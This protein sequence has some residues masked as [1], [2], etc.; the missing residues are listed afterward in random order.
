[1]AALLSIAMVAFYA[2]PYDVVTRLWVI[3]SALTGV[4]FPAFAAALLSDRQRALNLFASGVRY[5]FVVLAP[6][7]LV[8]VAFAHEGLLWWLGAEFALESERVVQWLAVGVLI[9]SLARM[10][11]A[12]IQAAGKPDWTAKLHLLELVPYLVSVWWLVEAFGVTGAAMAWTLRAVVDTALLFLVASRLMPG[13]GSRLGA[14]RWV[15]AATFMVLVGVA[16]MTEP[17]MKMGFCA[18]ALML[19]G[20]VVWR[21]LLEPGEIGRFRAYFRMTPCS[22]N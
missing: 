22:A 7:V 21:W 5:V 6:V 19:F 15:G 1:V 10:P 17:L 20:A 8:V 16:L 14:L 4:L 12:L 9:N 13:I 11:Y 2:T 18:G 3:P